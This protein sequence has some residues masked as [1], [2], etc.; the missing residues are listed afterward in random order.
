MLRQF[1]SL[2]EA[3]D[4]FYELIRLEPCLATLWSVCAG[5]DRD[6]RDHDESDDPYDY[7]PFTRDLAAAEER[8][9]EEDFFFE[10]VKATLV[11]LVGKYRSGGPPELQTSEAYETA[12]RAL[13][14]LLRSRLDEEPTAFGRPRDLAATSVDSR[15]T[16]VTALMGA[17]PQNCQR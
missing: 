9:D 4:A 13:L 10:H 17:C 1:S 2:E 15:R 3:R 5:A 7:D 14:H 11:L 16:D 6:R 8:W 12:Y